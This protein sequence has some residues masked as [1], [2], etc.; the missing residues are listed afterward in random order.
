WALVQAAT[1]R[2]MLLLARADARY[3]R[4][5]RDSRDLLSKDRGGLLDPGALVQRHGPDWL[6]LFRACGV[7][8]V[9]RETVSGVGQ[10]P[11]EGKLQR[12]ASALSQSQ[13][14]EGIWCSRNLRDSA[15]ADALGQSA[16]CGLLAVPL[17]IDDGKPG[18]FLMFRPEQIE[19]RLWAGKPEGPVAMGDG[20]LQ[21]L[22]RN[23]FAAWREEIR[24]CSEPWSAIEQQAAADLGEDLAV[25][26]FSR[27]IDLLNA[28]LTEANR[29]LE[30]LAHTDA[31]TSVWNRYHTEKQIDAAINAAERAGKPCTLLLFDVDHFKQVNDR[32]GHEAGDRVLTTLARE[33]DQNLRGGDYLGRWG[34]EEFVVVASG[35][36]LEAGGT[37][38]ERL[39]R[40][41]A[42]TRFCG[43]ERITI[44]VGV[45]TWREGDSR[46]TL[47]DRADRAMYRAKHDGRNRV[48]EL[49]S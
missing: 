44:S 15:L 41:V 31:L 2:L 35:N 1:A 34:G 20:R 9:Y 12:L 5:V 14:R 40:H 28:R 25:L 45:A 3:L 42:E 10:L 11:S 49:D 47:L 43:V 39:R 18:W 24:G 13:P 26:V 36:N 22:P 7:A 6:A 30:R 16:C 21:L 29:R 27:E 23:S 8:L 33:I 19:T 17:P 48:V 32:L 4:R 46:R 37:L 38:A